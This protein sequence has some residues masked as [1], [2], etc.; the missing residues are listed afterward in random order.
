MLWGAK[1]EG[2]KDIP[3]VITLFPYLSDGRNGEIDVANG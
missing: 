2:I 3:A 1:G